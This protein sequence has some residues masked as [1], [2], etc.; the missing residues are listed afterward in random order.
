MIGIVIVSHSHQLALGVQELANQMVQGQVRI[1]TAGGLAG[2]EEEIGTDAFRVRDAIESVYSEEGVL[3]LMDLGSA[4]MSAEMALEFLPEERRERVLL[5][6]APLVEGAI[7]AAVQAAA[8]S[9]LEEVCREAR[10]ALRSKYQQLEAEG[11]G[12]EEVVEETEGAE[13][14]VTLNI[15]NQ[16][17]LH[18]RPAARFVTTAARFEA[19]IR[20][21]N[22]TTGTGPVNAKSIGQVASL[23][24]EHGHEVRVTAEGAEAQAALEALAQ[25]AR[26]KFGETRAPMEGPGPVDEPAA[27]A[28]TLPEGRLTGTPVSPGLALGPAHL[29]EATRLEAESYAV[30]DPDAEVDRLQAAL[31]TAEEQLARLQEQAES[32]VGPEEAEIFE[33]QRLYLKD[34]DL[35]EQIKGTIREEGIN[36]EAAWQRGI[37]GMAG[38][39]RELESE[40]LR[41]RA[42]DVEDVGQRVLRVLMD[43]DRIAQTLEEPVVLIAAELAPSDV[44]ELDVDRLLAI[45]TAKG[46][47]TSHTAI[48][49]RALGIPAL[50]GVGEALL[51]VPPG[52]ELLVDGERGVVHVDPG[53]EARDN[54][55]Q[56]Q[57]DWEAAQEAAQALAHEPAVT[58]DGHR[59]EVVANIGSVEEARRALEYGAEGVGLLRTEFLYLNREEAPGEEEQYELYHAI[60]EVMEERPLI[61][62]TLDV[63]GDKP[64]PYVELPREE[65][66]FLG[67]RGIRLALGRPALFKTQLRAILRATPGHQVKIMFPMVATVEEVR[68]A[69][70]LLDEARQELEAEGQA[71]AQDLEIGIMVEIPAA[72]VVA[73]QLAKEVDFFSIGTNDL[74]QYTM[75]ADRTNA[76]VNHLSDALHPAVL[77]LIREVIQKAHRAGLWV[78]LCGE[79]AGDPIAA[80]ILLGLGLDEFSMAPPAIPAVKMRIGNLTLEQAQTMAEEALEL[81][82]PQEVREF[83]E[84]RLG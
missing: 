80:P 79:L 50:V 27:E 24:A 44:V 12:L 69:R 59:V 57:R 22:A 74:S 43:A 21:Y 58:Q 4:L 30:E 38:M 3:V 32:E 16:Q 19:E 56:R 15:E 70:R 55:L 39:L 8:G 20:A 77:R 35:L 71:V 47:A 67:W 33:A 83:V 18:A 26:E 84:G 73:D 40:Y 66:P 65:N 60:A 28:T 2:P 31:A 7:A 11:P 75:A 81:R 48:L 78:G 64:L 42:A 17:G 82:S 72:A 10:G 9:P 53:P 36:A 1:A 46:G 76:N 6:A 14:E 13:H 25:L 5:C 23:G 51:D 37:E 62:R 49:S 34:P 52:T 68:E 29:F 63:G 54:F 45:C 61:I 41:E